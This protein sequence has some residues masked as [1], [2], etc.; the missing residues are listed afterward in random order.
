MAAR[1]LNDAVGAWDQALDNYLVEIKQDLS[2]PEK[3]RALKRAFDYAHSEWERIA[4][5]RISAQSN[6]K[7]PHCGVN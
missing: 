4:A 3:R 1:T 2:D 7:C 6:C 5:E